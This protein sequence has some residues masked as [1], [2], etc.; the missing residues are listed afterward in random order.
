[1]KCPHC[2]KEIDDKLISKHLGG[3]GGEGNKG[4]KRPDMKK[5]GTTY[6]KRWGKKK[7]RPK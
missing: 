6:E 7:G 5:G 2:R 3:R 4:N 1:M